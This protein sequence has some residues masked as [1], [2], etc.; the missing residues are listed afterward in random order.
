MALAAGLSEE[1]LASVLSNFDKK[2]GDIVARLMKIK[3]LLDIK[4]KK[5]I[6]K[7]HPKC[8][9]IRRDGAQ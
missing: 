4:I 7:L 5:E 1:H 2:D 8:V 3:P 6:L 9:L